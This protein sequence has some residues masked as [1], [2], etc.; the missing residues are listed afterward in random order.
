MLN[1]LDAILDR[2]RPNPSLKLSHRNTWESHLGDQTAIAYRLPQR[3]TTCSQPDHDRLLSTTV[4]H[5]P[6][7][8][9]MAFFRPR[10]CPHQAA[11]TTSSPHNPSPRPIGIM[12]PKQLDT[13]TGSKNN[14]KGDGSPESAH[15][16]RLLRYLFGQGAINDPAV[17]PTAHT[18]PGENSAPQPPQVYASVTTNSP[19]KV[20]GYGAPYPK[21]ER[22]WGSH[23]RRALHAAHR[24]PQALQR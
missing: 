15:S 8:A 19:R 6:T 4:L 9:A 3:S 22:I 2:A 16:T 7:R 13:T 23:A 20:N 14:C 10:R 24:S 17:A 11:E 12:T 18:V 1:A 5:M 21:G